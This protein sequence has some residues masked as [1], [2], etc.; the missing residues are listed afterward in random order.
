MMFTTY[1]TALRFGSVQ[2]RLQ[3]K[4]SEKQAKAP[5]TTEYQSLQKLDV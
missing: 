2:Q 3:E 4:K 1:I 5:S